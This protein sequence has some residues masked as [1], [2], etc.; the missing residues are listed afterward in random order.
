MEL[1]EQQKRFADNYIE[2]LNATQSYIDAGYKARGSSAEVN[3]SRLL[4]NAKVKEYI[5]AQM[6]R[7]QKEKIA[8][9]QEI[10]EYLTKAM[11]GEIEEEIVVTVGT[12]EGRSMSQSVKKQLSAKDRTKA[13]ELLG[14]RYALW[15]DKTE[16][17]GEVGVK[18]VDDID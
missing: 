1:T 13:A 16:H 10:L 7:L 2:T 3:G 11:K 9:Q 17:S 6:L 4:R 8:S 18:I 14:K 5:D 15:T 12:G